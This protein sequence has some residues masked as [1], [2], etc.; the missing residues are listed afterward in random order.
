M[1]GDIT[2]RPLKCINCGA[3]LPVR[4]QFVTFQ[5]GTCFSYQIITEEGL[6]PVSV[7]R[8]QAADCEAE[9]TIWLPF[10]VVEIDRAKL[11]SLMR[12][13]LTRL[14]D[15]TRIIASTGLEKEKPEPELPFVET[16]GIDF[17][18][19]RTRLID[20]T[21][22]SKLLP[23]GGEIDHLM[24]RIESYGAFRIYVPAFHSRNALANLK[25]GHLLTRRQPPY[26]IARLNQPGHQVRCVLHAADAVSLIDYIFISTLPD[27][28]QQC[29]DLIQ[30]VVLE[31]AAP[32][33]LI[34]FPFLRK[35]V[36]LASLL[37]DF[38]ISSRLIETM[39][40]PSSVDKGV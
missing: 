21:I 29:G 28:I 40:E 25:V 23:S 19:K 7:F 36:S 14:T 27:A 12:G 31:P 3:E 32:P 9:E 38:H 17:Q 35:G 6:A 13:S 33:R 18:V 5:C 22:E 1:S 11:R 4:G 24:E 39:T 34:E 15:A 2:V 10:W 8:A 37:G 26:R 20:E 16:V 30:N